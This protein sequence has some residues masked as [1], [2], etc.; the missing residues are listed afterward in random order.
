MLLI[1]LFGFKNAFTAGPE[2]VAAIN[3][4]GLCTDTQWDMLKA[5]TTVAKVNISKNRYNYK[6]E[7]KNAY[8]YTLFV[9][10]TAIIMSIS[11]LI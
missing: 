2:Y 9:I 7:L 6:K 8:I 3:L 10:L 4:I 5:I 11:F 1:Y